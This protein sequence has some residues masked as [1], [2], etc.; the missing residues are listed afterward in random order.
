MSS[1]VAAKAETL[2]HKSAEDEK[3]LQWPQAP[4]AIFGF[5]AQQAAEKLLKALLAQIGVEFELTHDLTNLQRRLRRST[6]H[7]PIL[8]F[9]YE[10]SLASAL[11]IATNSL[12]F[13]KIRTAQL[14]LKQYARC[15]CTS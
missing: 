7:F 6:S 8:E 2:L 1:Q 11:S 10:N 12:H 14:S 3:V 15:A 5:H 13:P 9:H 4:D